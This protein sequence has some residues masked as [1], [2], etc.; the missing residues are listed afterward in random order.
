MTLA[1][2]ISFG[3]ALACALAYAA[4]PY[5]ILLADRLQF[6]DK[7]AGYKGHAHPT[8]YLG[9]A[10][11]MGGFVIAVLVTAGD[12]NKTIPLVGGIGLLWVVGTV[13]D[14]RTVPP[15]W[16]VLVE[17]ALAWMVWASGLGWHLGA[18][19][20][21]DLG[22]HLRVGRRGRQRLQPLRQHG[23]SGQHD[24]ARGLCGCRD[25]WDSAR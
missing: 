23:W 15:G 9:G 4:T 11:L 3:F 19:A 17:L 6:Y 7:P 25:P 5:A 24:G 13:D 16:R 14:R 10:A 20:L 21:V 8:P 22:R 18:G 1:L 2:R 12:W